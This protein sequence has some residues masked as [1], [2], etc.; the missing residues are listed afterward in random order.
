MESFIENGKIVTSYSI[1]SEADLH[2]EMKSLLQ[3]AMLTSEDDIMLTVH[4]PT[5]VALA[6]LYAQFCINKGINPIP[7]L[8][9]P[10][11]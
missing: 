7:E 2:K 5:F 9:K 3:E 6:K 8:A 1:G 4:T 11:M 10:K